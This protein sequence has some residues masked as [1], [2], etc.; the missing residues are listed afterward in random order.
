MWEADYG[1]N[2]STNFKDENHLRLLHSATDRE[3]NRRKE[4]EKWEGW[5]LDKEESPEERNRGTQDTEQITKVHVLP[6]NL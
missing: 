5:I 6:D 1:T 4:E 3:K 2:T